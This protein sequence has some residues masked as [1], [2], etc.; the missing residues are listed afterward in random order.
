MEAISMDDVASIDEDLCIGCGVCAHGC[1][2]EAI[3]LERTGKR[4][5]FVPPIRK[6]A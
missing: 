6:T 4:E 3:M 1:P 5:V 2:A